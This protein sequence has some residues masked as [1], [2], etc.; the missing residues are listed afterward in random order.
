MPQMVSKVGQWIY[1]LNGESKPVPTTNSYQRNPCRVPIRKGSLNFT[2]VCLPP[3]GKLQFKPASEDKM[4]KRDTRSFLH[5][6]LWD[7]SDKKT[8]GVNELSPYV[9]CHNSISRGNS[10]SLYINP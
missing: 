7:Q 6:H 2:A 8:A 1:M 10:L 5:F 4:W 3:D 9:H